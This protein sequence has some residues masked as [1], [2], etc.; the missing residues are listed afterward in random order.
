MTT[1]PVIPPPQQIALLIVTYQSGE[2]IQ[3]CLSSLPHA[4]PQRKLHLIIIDNA[5]TDDTRE[6]IK[7][8]LR[9]YPAERISHRLICNNTNLGFT[10]AV[11]QALAHAPDGA[12]VLFLNPDTV[13]PPASLSVLMKKLFGDEKL[14]VIA[15]Q[16]RFLSSNQTSAAIQPSCRRFPTY[17]DLFYE[18]TGLARAFPNS[19]RCNRWK[20]GDFDHRTSR[21]VDQPQ[22]ACLLA[23][24]EVIR[25]VGKWDERFPLFFSDVD[26][27]RRVW[28]AGWKI[29][30]DAEAFVYHEQGAS[31]KQIRPRAIW[32]SHVSFWRYFR[33][34]RASWGEEILSLVIGPVL[35]LAA[36]LRIF[37]AGITTRRAF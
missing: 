19:A 4:E 28:Q 8:A 17:S 36:L 1:A 14:G 32:S 35:V 9:P 15:P 27:C 2:H 11:N 6:Q 30:F 23:K 22:G 7:I 3:A 29:Y 31:V 16:L 12:A 24:P 26:W 20:M 37:W 10:R 5:S 13:L 25:Q 21:E 18:F 33:K 34:W